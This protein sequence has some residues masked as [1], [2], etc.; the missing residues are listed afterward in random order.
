MAHY[1]WPGA[2]STGLDIT[3]ARRQSVTLSKSQRV[4]AALPTIRGNGGRTPYPTNRP[5]HARKRCPCT[6][7]HVAISAH[8]RRVSR[9]YIFFPFLSILFASVPTGFP[10]GSLALV[11]YTLY[12]F[13][14]NVFPLFLLWGCGLSLPTQEPHT[15]N[16]AC[17][18][19]AVIR[20]TRTKRGYLPKTFGHKGGWTK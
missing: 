20:C 5:V 10:Q 4:R 9:C 13:L 15:W 12:F 18:L 17:T 1:F 16:L 6:C 7:V 3:A 8:E 11:Q 19:L 14:I 2:R